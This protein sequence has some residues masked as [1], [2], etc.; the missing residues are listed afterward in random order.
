MSGRLGFKMGNWS[1]LTLLLLLV[2]AGVFSSEPQFLPLIKWYVLV[3][4]LPVLGRDS[5][6]LSVSRNLRDLWHLMILPQIVNFICRMLI[7]NIPLDV[8]LYQNT[9][10]PQCRSRKIVMGFFSV[11]DFFKE[12][13][14]N[15]F[16]S[17]IKFNSCLCLVLVKG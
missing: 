15:H 4:Y 5:A 11:L 6:Q 1:V 14:F 9:L 17:K 8:W 7:L 13:I 2:R 16:F 12:Q 3:I 10:V